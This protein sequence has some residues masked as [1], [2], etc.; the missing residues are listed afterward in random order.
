V[1]DTGLL[2][3]PETSTDDCQEKEQ[4]EAMKAKKRVR[5]GTFDVEVDGQKIAVKGKEVIKDRKGKSKMTFKAKGT[6]SSNPI[7]RINDKNVFKNGYTKVDKKKTVY[8]TM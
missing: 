4:K 5:K 8:K 3:C 2:R 1:K 6:D 7:K